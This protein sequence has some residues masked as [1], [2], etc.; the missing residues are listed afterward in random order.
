[1]GQGG[2]GCRIEKCGLLQ[3][4]M[5]GH[6]IHGSDAKL[7]GTNEAWCLHDKAPTSL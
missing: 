1:M 6:E 3:H 4:W 5:L 2:W 7:Q